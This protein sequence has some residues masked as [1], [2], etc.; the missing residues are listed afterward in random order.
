MHLSSLEAASS[1]EPV[2]EG[3][4]HLDCVGFAF[5]FHVFILVQRLESSLVICT[6]R[7]LD[8]RR[9]DL[10]FGIL[11]WRHVRSSGCCRTTCWTN[12]GVEIST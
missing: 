12:L 7:V 11:D 8:V 3:K 6:S 10:E 9:V 1:I 4:T 2:I 5:N